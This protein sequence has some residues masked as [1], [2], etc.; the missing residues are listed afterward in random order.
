MAWFGRSDRIDDKDR[1]GDRR[2]EGYS[3]T[4]HRDTRGDRFNGDVRVGQRFS[5][6]QVALPAAYRARYQDSDTSFYR[7][8]ED[9][10]YQI[11]RATGVIM[12]MFRIDD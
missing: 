5:D 6:R 4:D 9:R 11:D 1:P 3:Q 7:Y 12:A 2:W 8:D 10:I